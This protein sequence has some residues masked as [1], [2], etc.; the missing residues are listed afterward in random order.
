MNWFSTAGISDAASAMHKSNTLATNWRRNLN[1]FNLRHKKPE[2]TN[3]REVILLFLL[4]SFQWYQRSYRILNSYA[5]NH[6]KTFWYIFFQC[7]LYHKL[8]KSQKQIFLAPR[9]RYGFHF[10]YFHFNETRYYNV[11]IGVYKNNSLWKTLLQLSSILYEW[12]GR[13]HLMAG[14]IRPAQI[15]LNLRCTLCIYLA[16]V[17]S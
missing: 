12:P 7:V 15:E 10:T 4:F 9:R 3:A 13:V 16:N 2:K 8:M 5:R 6:F 11:E 14:I 17:S 1:I